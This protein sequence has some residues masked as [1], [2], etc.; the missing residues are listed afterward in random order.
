MA[1][2]QFKIVFTV[3]ADTDMTL[4]DIEREVQYTMLGGRGAITD[5]VSGFINDDFIPQ[6]S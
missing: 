4:E 2:R 5:F 3:S 1:L 6:D